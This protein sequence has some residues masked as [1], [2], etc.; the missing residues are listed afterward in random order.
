[1][2]FRGFNLGSII[3]GV[4]AHL[5]I[6]TRAV[7]DRDGPMCYLSDLRPMELRKGVKCDA[8]KNR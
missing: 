2:P 6:D 4:V 1:M 8:H 3:I 5:R 7:S